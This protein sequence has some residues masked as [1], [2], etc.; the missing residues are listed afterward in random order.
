MGLSFKEIVDRLRSQFP[1]VTFETVE[2]NGDPYVVVDKGALLDVARFLKDT[3]DL[4]F[5]YLASLGGTDDLVNLWSVMHLYSIRRIHRFVIKVKL[6]R[7][8]PSVASLCD[9]WPTANWHEREAYDLYGIRYEGHPDL[10]RIL[11][12]EDW[13]GYPMRKDY[14]FPEHYQGIPLK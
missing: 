1:A 9:L 13:P 10:R 6:D 7:T 12:P 4:D 11:L 5:D 2:P 14:D 8:D 3:T